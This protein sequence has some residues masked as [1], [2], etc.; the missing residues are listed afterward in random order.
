MVRILPG[1][2]LQ[3][4]I[5]V[6]NRFLNL[7]GLEIRLTAF[8]MQIGNNGSR[9]FERQCFGVGGD[10]F[11]ILAQGVVQLAL[12]EMQAWVLRFSR[13]GAVRKLHCFL[14]L[15]GAIGFGRLVY[16][17]KRTRLFVFGLQPVKIKE[18][19][20]HQEQNRKPHELH[21]PSLRAATESA[22]ANMT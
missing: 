12:E 13:H 8:L 6:G 19:D 1:H 18:I 16:P 9:R 14:Y 22:T 3:I 2:V 10:G 17:D 5:K 7:G 20:C 11:I 4:S 15:A 21:A